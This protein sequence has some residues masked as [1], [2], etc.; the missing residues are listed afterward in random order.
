[1]RTEYCTVQRFNKRTSSGDLFMDLKKCELT[2]LCM[3]FFFFRHG[4]PE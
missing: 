1:M 2:Y 4:R 3:Q